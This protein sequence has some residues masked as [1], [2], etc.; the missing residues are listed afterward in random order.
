MRI[1]IGKFDEMGEPVWFDVETN[2]SE[3]GDDN[4]DTCETAVV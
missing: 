3:G 1:T 4:E 2:E